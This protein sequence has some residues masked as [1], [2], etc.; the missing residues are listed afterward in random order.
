[1]LHAARL[2]TVIHMNRIG[3]YVAART[4]MPN[5]CS[6]VRRLVA[7]FAAEEAGVTA[8]EYGL[9]AALIAVTCIAVFQLTGAS[10]M[11]LYAFWSAAVSAAL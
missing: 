7:R 2:S 6:A 8:I 9:L 11:A 1:M 3:T 5:A 4:A 10:M